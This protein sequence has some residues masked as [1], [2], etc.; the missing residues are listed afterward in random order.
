VTTPGSRIVIGSSTATSSDSLAANHNGSLA[1]AR[2]TT[3][4]IALSVTV[5]S[6]VTTVVNR[7]PGSGYTAQYVVKN[8]SSIS[9]VFLINAT[10]TA[11]T[12]AFLTPGVLTGT[13]ISGSGADGTVTLAAGDSVFANVTY[14]VATGAAA[15]EGL[16]L[17]ASS[18]LVN[19]V[20][21]TATLTVRRSPPQMILVRAVDV[22]LPK[23]GD[24]VTYTIE[25]QNVGEA[26]AST[27]QVTDSLGASLQFKVASVANAMLGGLSATVQY[28]TDNLVWT[29]VPVSGGCSAPAG[30]DACVKWIRWNIAQAVPV[31]TGTVRAA[32]FKYKARVR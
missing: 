20:S 5:R 13:G 22:S 25:T 27:V 10:T 29:Y 24:E 17:S 3:N 12:G 23:P 1:A 14:A 9:A 19:S 15:N 28:S 2:V 21:A 7:L 32:Q 11:G 16:L 6:V 31:T 8:T 30:Y 26:L 4:G 18:A